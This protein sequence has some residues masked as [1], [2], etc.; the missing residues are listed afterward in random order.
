MKRF[1]WCCVLTLFVLALLADRV[2]EAG[3]RVWGAKDYWKTILMGYGLEYV[4]D[5]HYLYYTINELAY[6]FKV[7]KTEVNSAR[8]Q[9]I[10]GY[11]DDFLSSDS[12]KK[13]NKGNLKQLKALTGFEQKDAHSTFTEWWRANKSLYTPTGTQVS[14]FLAE[15]KAQ[16]FIAG[17][18]IYHNENLPPGFD[19]SFIDDV[20]PYNMLKL[21][22]EESRI[23]KD[24]QVR[25]LRVWRNLCIEGI[26]FPLLIFFLAYSVPT[27]AGRMKAK[28]WQR[29][30]RFSL[31]GILIYL[32]VSLPY[33]FGYDW[34]INTTCIRHGTLLYSG[35]FNLAFNIPLLLSFPIAIP[36]L[37]LQFIKFGGYLLNY[38]CYPCLLWANIPYTHAEK[39]KGEVL[40]LGIIS[41][42]AIGAI[43]AA[44]LRIREK[45]Q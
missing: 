5:D 45:R 3:P 23:F 12:G 29:W 9:A 25:R 42:A 43:I 28:S 33:L 1:V 35:F 31:T 4:Q 24:V 41:Y 2:L 40:L 18:V 38:L 30:L 37:Y 19:I 39:D 22:N 11:I 44:I 21:Y 16:S 34:G 10:I 20:Y 36:L 17:L 8:R 14:A 26:Y 7:L 27:V 32:G 6:D 13:I 15:R